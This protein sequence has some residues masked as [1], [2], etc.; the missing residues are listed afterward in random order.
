MALDEP[1]ETDEKFDIDKFQFVVDKDFLEKAQPIK[2][3]Y[4]ISGFKL[5][6]S[7][8]FG[9][10]PCSGCGTEQDTSSCCG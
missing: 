5:D 8:D 3:D 10:S 6:C 2:V 9:A 4:L 1:R 7:I